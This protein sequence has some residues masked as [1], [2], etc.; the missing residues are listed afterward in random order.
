M[1]NPT[2]R[3]LRLLTMLSAVTLP[4]RCPLTPLRR[5]SSA[6]LRP[7]PRLRCS[8]NNEQQPSPPPSTQPPPPASGGVRLVRVET[9]EAAWQGVAQR[10]DGSQSAT[11]VAKSCATLLAGDVAALLLFALLGRSSHGEALLFSDVWSTALPF[12]AAWLLSA[13]FT[14]AFGDAARGSDVGAAAGAALKS[15]CVAGPAGLALRAVAQARA[16]PPAFVAVA[17]V[18]T[19][20]L[21]VGWRALAAARTP[22]RDRALAART[23]RQGNP[24]EFLSLLSGLV[25]RW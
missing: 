25:K 14:G 7:A 16:P 17:L 10:D 1:E 9:R 2:H 21:L 23:S 12:V 5:A 22:K 18:A 15:C 20:L 19:S 8:G 3:S 13:P 4:A 11:E 24:L 6:R